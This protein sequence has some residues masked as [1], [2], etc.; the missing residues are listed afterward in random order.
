MLLPLQSLTRTRL[1][2]ALAT[3]LC[4]WNSGIADKGVAFASGGPEADSRGTNSPACESLYERF[5][6]VLSKAGHLDGRGGK[7]SV[8]RIRTENGQEWIFGSPIALRDLKDDILRAKG[9]AALLA[10]QP[11]DSIETATSITGSVTRTG[12]MKGFGDVDLER[13]WVVNVAPGRAQSLSQADSPELRGL[14]EHFKKNVEA[15]VAEHPEFVFIELKAGEFIHPETGEI[16]GIKWTLED[17]RR[18]WKTV[19]EKSG[20]RKVTLEQVFAENARI[21]VDWAVPSVQKKPLPGAYQEASVLYR[22]GVRA[23]N[24]DVRLR[25]GVGRNREALP[26]RTGS[27]GLE[28]EQSL[29][30]LE[31]S[32]AQEGMSLEEIRQSMMDFDESDFK[33][34]A[35]KFVKRVYAFL[36]FWPDVKEYG[37]L[38]GL[39]VKSSELE[40]SIVEVMGDPDLVRMSQIRAQGKLFEVLQEHGK[41]AP[42]GAFETWLSQFGPEATLSSVIADL[43][44]RMTRRTEELLHSR[45]K[46]RQY[47][48]YQRSRIPFTRGALSSRPVSAELTPDPGWAAALEARFQ[49]WR[50]AYPELL[51]P[52]G[53]GL[54]L[55]LRKL[56]YLSENSRAAIEKQ[57]SGLTGFDAI[58]GGL[59]LSSDQRGLE[60]WYRI[61]SADA[62]RLARASDVWVGV[63]A[64][65]DRMLNRA[66]PERRWEWIRIPVAALNPMRQ[67][68]EEVLSRF[69]YDEHLGTNLETLPVRG[70]KLAE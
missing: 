18:G 43:E 19:Q 35:F 22:I 56:G 39:N 57:V 9:L 58:D 70:L 51:F 42:G 65:P 13:L 40:K 54:R 33:T 64:L 20:E 61:P 28:P 37:R 25:P 69:L 50:T 5:D 38:H 55:E 45:P 11:S 4:V 16:K 32:R 44:A 59:H 34:N 23:G 10:D 63:G 14:V 1:L 7:L 67:G 29:M 12:V 21:K 6:R 68:G 53:G 31:A 60:L 48:D 47:V 27:V 49:A 26:Y 24:N 3:A 8:R 66:S 52:E 36:K 15:T 17:I 41:T 30:A 62:G 2:A 46:L